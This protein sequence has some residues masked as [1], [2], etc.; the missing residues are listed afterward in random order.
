MMGCGIGKLPATYLGLP[1]GALFK[2]RIVWDVVEERIFK[3]SAF[4]K[5]Q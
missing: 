2:A 4:W 3:R 1:L 5:R